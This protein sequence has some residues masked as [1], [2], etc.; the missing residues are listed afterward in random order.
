MMQSNETRMDS[1][2]PLKVAFFVR[3]ETDSQATKED[4]SLDAQIECLDEFVH[5]RY[6]T[7]ESWVVAEIL[8]EGEKDG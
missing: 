2:A 6:Q 3:G 7:G 1:S 8:I 5:L 4:R